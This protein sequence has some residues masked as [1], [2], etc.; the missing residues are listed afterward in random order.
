MITKAE[1]KASEQDIK[2][3]ANKPV[4]EHHQLIAKMVKQL[5]KV[6]LNNQSLRSDDWHLYYQ[7]FTE[8]QGYYRRKVSSN[9]LFE[10][11]H[12][13]HQYNDVYL[14]D[15]KTHQTIKLVDV[16]NWALKQAT[17]EQQ[18]RVAE[19]K[20]QVEAFGKLIDSCNPEQLKYIQLALGVNTVDEFRRKY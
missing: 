11:L 15:P 1:I 14:V 3:A 12:Y 20:A 13:K 9:S 4:A 10:D 16:Y 7:L 6:V 8:L 2:A 17:A 5:S 18:E 19:R